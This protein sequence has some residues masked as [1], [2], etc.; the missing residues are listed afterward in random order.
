FGS[1]LAVAAVAAAALVV[2]GRLEADLRWRDGGAR[3]VDLFGT[4]DAGPPEA[5]KASEPLWKDGSA[6]AP[7]VPQGVPGSFAAL[8]GQAPPGVV[9][10]QPSKKVRGAAIPR[11]E[12]FFYGLPMPEGMERD[13]PALGSGFVISRDGYIVTN[14]H[15][16]ED[17]ESIKVIFADGK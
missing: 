3:A 1:A 7:H 14:A 5:A 16:I 10:I 8:P 15:V 4:K 11:F 9:N 12:D 2:S 13:V 17:V 6:A